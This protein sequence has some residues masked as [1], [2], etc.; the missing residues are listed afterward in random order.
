MVPAGSR[1]IGL[2]AAL[3]ALVGIVTVVYTCVEVRGL[4][5]GGD[6]L[7]LRPSTA[8]PVEVSVMPLQEDSFFTDRNTVKVVVP[9][10]MSLDE[11]IRI[12]QVERSRPYLESKVPG[13]QLRA[14]QVL[15]FP[16]T[17]RDKDW[18]TN[19]KNQN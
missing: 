4:S 10:S 13:S 19:G 12:Y 6:L 2:P 7:L 11:F 17:E 18:V 1:N 16:L 3:L 15:E 8:A 5:G 9:R 14:T